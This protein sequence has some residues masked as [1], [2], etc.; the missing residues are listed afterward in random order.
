MI[1]YLGL[2]SN[3]GDLEENM[4]VVFNKIADVQGCKILQKSGVY[5]TKAWGFEEQD[6]F[7][8]MVL[9]IETD[10]SPEVFI[11]Y[12]KDIEVQMGR[13]KTHKWGPRVMDIDILYC[14]DMVVDM[15]EL[16][17]PHPHLHEREFVLKPLVEI[18]KEFVHPVLN[19]TNGE[20]YDLL[21]GRCQ[22]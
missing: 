17:I 4:R 21:E 9:E 11:K 7:L 18:A 6:D 14:D 16:V 1:Y 22:A 20:L 19:R 3:I 5:K 2:G 15:D 8:N 13:V 12:L 10:I